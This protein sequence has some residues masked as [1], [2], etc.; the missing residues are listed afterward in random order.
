MGTLAL[1]LGLRDGVPTAFAPDVPFLWNVTPT[2]EEWACGYVVNGPFK[3]DPGRTHVS[4]DDDTT[5]RVVGGLGDELG[6]GLIELHDVLT[7]GTCAMQRPM[8]GG[9]GENF[10][11]SLWE[12]L[13]SGTDNPDTLRRSFLLRLH[14][15]CRGISAWMA[16]RS[17]VPTNLPAPFSPRLPPLSSEMSW[18][19]AT[20][21]LDSPALCAALAEID[22]EDFRSLVGSRRIVSSETNRLLVPLCNL[23]SAYGVPFSPAPV[24]PASLLAELAERW[25]YLLTPTRLHALR[26]L[27]QDAAWGLVSNDPQGAPWRR[28][29]RARSVAGTSQPL[30][31]V[32]VQRASGVRHEADGD[33]DDELLRSAIA[34][35]NRILDSAYI[36]RPEDWTV[37]RWLRVQHRVDAAEIADWYMDVEEDLRPGALRYLLDGK[38]AGFRP[39]PPHLTQD[40]PVVASGLRWHQPNARRN[41]RGTLA[42]PETPGSPLPR[43]VSVV[44]AVTTAAG[45]L[46]H[47]LQPAVGN[48]GTMPPCAVK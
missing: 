43:P 35:T 8:L 46:R 44:R 19:V 4:L 15:N 42:A 31:G 11:S 45:R 1:A 38:T 40:T 48:G 30:R 32:L 22:D 47:N 6:K 16:A 21:G 39:S 28:S 36:G 27:A 2:S 23:A 3:L 10:L 25:E 26:P 13:A 37:F 20:D 9:N 33:L 12:V 5:R 34:P 24:R 14:G 7:D 17:V 18:E 41:L 29:F